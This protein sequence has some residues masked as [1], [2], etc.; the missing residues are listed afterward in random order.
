MEGIHKVA[1]LI[2]ICSIRVS[3]FQ[4][5]YRFLCVS[6]LCA[7]GSSGKTSVSPCTGTF[8]LVGLLDTSTPGHCAEIAVNR[9]RLEQYLPYICGTRRLINMMSTLNFSRRSIWSRNLLACLFKLIFDHKYW[10]SM[11]LRNVGKHHT[12]QQH[13]P[14]D[15]TLRSLMSLQNTSRDLAWPT[16]FILHL[17]NLFL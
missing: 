11:F 4:F 2:P 9:W 13:I 7:V 14:D 1:A 17:Q 3:L 5:V 10:G 8:R 6:L 12:A 16:E 15:S